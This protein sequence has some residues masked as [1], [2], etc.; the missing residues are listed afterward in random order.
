MINKNN[1]T[2]TKVCGNNRD[3]ENINNSYN[4]YSSNDNN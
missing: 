4:D 1:N 3:H 2:T